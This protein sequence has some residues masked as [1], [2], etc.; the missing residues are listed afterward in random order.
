MTPKIESVVA[1]YLLKK[2]G[3]N[4]IGVSIIFLDEV[5]YSKEDSPVFTDCHVRDLAKVKAICDHLKIQFYAA[6][7]VDLYRDR[8]VEHVVVNRL[9]GQAISPC[10]LCNRLKIEQLNAKADLLHADYVA[11]GHYVKS[12]ENKQ[13]QEFHLGASGDLEYDQSYFFANLEQSLLKKLI[14][15]LA[16]MRKS[17][18]DRIAR[19]IGLDHLI[20]IGQE[21]KGP[22]K[23]SCFYNNDFMPAFVEKRSPASLRQRGGLIA[24]E[25]ES[26]IAEHS[27]VHNYYVGQ[28]RIL[29]ASKAVVDPSLEVIKMLPTDKVVYLGSRD[30]FSYDYCLLTEFSFLSKTDCTRPMAVFA[31]FKQRGELV[32]CTLT[33]KNHSYVVLK[34]TQE[35]KGMII[36]GTYAVIY[37]R[38]GSGA[39]LL[40][41]GAVVQS[42]MMQVVDRVGN[43]DVDEDEIDESKKDFVFKF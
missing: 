19:S 41:G 20:D 31:K 42:G 17:D 10:I 2:N 7:A 34:F 16:D 28:S 4:C 1:A 6:N 21:K 43:E 13:R 5:K 35:Y 26:F 37:D 9:N 38:M 33:L 12:I 32:A 39:I 11:T 14:F 18:V 29:A 36:P 22:K 8:V 40:G 27:G 25:G 15:P 23:K 24:Y 30:I 3:Y